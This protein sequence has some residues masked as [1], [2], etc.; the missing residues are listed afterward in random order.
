MT[1]GTPL[2][3]LVVVAD[4]LTALALPALLGGRDP[5]PV[6]AP[7][8][9]SLARRGKV[10]ANAYTA[11]PLCGPSRGA[12]M[13][14]LLPS[15]SG[16]FDNGCEW[17]SDIPTF[18]HRLRN[19]G[20][21]TILAGKMHF[22]GADQL[23]GF[24]ERLT[25]DIYPSDFTWVPNWQDK[26]DRPDWFHSMDSVLNAGPVLRSNQI[27]FDEEVA[28]AARRKLFD[29]ARKREDTRPFCMVVSF[30]HPHDPFNI[31]PR[32][33][34]LYAD[35]EISLPNVPAAVEAHPSEDRIRAACG[36]EAQPPSNADILRARRAYYGAISYVDHQLGQLL[37][38]LRET[39]LDKT[40]SIVF[41][42]DH[43]EMLGEHGQWYK[44]SFREGA[45]R[46]PLIMST[47]DDDQPLRITQAVNLTDV[48][49]TLCALA[50]AAAAPQTDGRDLTPLLKGQEWGVDEVFGEYL[51]EGTFEPTV[52]IRREKWKFIHTPG[53]PDQLYDLSEDRDEE[54]NLAQVP[55]YAAIAHA[56]RTEALQRWDFG[57]L[58]ESV[59]LSQ[60]RRALVKRALATGRCTSWDYQPPA[61]AHRAYIRNHRPLEQLEA[62]ARLLP[63]GIG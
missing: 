20:Y 3:F 30:T 24:E 15:H 33:W 54:R 10:F 17:H 25:T 58:T 35:S 51:G 16:I 23:H 62:E 46:I 56:F 41:T 26:T 4:Q 8:L 60:Q 27:D 21:Q 31:E 32:W 22:V 57:K 47:P 52:M 53:D 2:N 39:G 1:K 37:A 43:G 6:K 50:G 38:V 40:T 48:G 9:E 14:G 36:I 55:A 59:L 18:G 49:E 19:A 28:Y 45:G 12:F 34:D 44:M 5:S 11:S 63:Q 7:V 61:N 42:S 29:L 13:T